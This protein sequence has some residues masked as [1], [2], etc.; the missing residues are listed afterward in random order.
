MPDSKSSLAVES[1]VLPEGEVWWRVQRLK[2]DG[3]VFY[4]GKVQALSVKFDGKSATTTK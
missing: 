3:S 4:P 2:A 1:G